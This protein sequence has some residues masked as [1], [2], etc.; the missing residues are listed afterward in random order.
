MTNAARLRAGPL[1]LAAA[2]CAYYNGL[3]NAKRL[4]DDAR[5]AARE[6]RPAEARALWAEAAV[7]AESVAIRYR[8]SGYRDDALLLQGLALR[9]SGSCTLALQPLGA[10][11]DSSPDPTLRERGSLLR[12]WALGQRCATNGSASITI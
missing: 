7:K 12:G 11:I 8:R 2:G 6:G 3:Y 1:L 10:V 5:R 4:A 9:E